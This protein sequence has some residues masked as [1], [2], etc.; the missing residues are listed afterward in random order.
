MSAYLYDIQHIGNGNCGDRRSNSSAWVKSSK[1]NSWNG[2]NYAP[3]NYEV[4][5]MYAGE[6]IE[7]GIEATFGSD[8][9]LPSDFSF[10]VWAEEDPVDITV[11]SHDNPSEHFPNYRMSESLQFYDLWGRLISGSDSSSGGE[12]GGETGG[13]TQDD[14]TSVENDFPIIKVSATEDFNEKF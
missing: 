1:D 4:V 11:T 12:T 10:V 8:N 6:K 3:H 9:L 2:F 5:E 13:D 14:D 7:I